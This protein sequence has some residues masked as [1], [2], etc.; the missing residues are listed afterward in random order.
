MKLILD[1]FLIVRPEFRTLTEVYLRVLYGKDNLSDANE[2]AK[3]EGDSGN[4]CNL[5][6]F[7]VTLEPRTARQIKLD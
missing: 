5:K 4:P 7:V 3:D 6:A 1:P 2:C